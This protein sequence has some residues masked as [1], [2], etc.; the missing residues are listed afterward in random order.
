MGDIGN[1]GETI[2]CPIITVDN[3]PTARTVG[4]Y[5]QSGNIVAQL[6]RVVEN[7]PGIV[8]S[9]NAEQPALKKPEDII[10]QRVRG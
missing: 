4:A 5:T 1:G 8:S 7:D 2:H 6:D 10:R 9:L 3:Q